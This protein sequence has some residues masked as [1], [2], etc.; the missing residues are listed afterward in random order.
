VY[1][2]INHPQV[3]WFNFN[4]TSNNN[5]TVDYL[6]TYRFKLEALNFNGAS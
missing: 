3:T 4:S 6:K 2:G 5:E 1:N